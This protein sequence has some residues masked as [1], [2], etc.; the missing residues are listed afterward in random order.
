MTTPTDPLFGQQWHFALMGD[1]ETIWNEYTGAGVDVGVYDDGVEKTHVDLNDNYNSALEFTY[2][3]TYYDPFPNSGTDGHGTSVAGIIAAEANNGRGGVG[4]AWGAN[5]TGLNFLEDIQFASNAVYEAATL[6]AQNFDVMNN[7]WG[8]TPLFDSSQNLASPVAHSSYLSEMFGTISQNGRGGLGTI[9]TKAAG[10]EDLNSNGD[11]AIASRYTLTV[12]AAD[13]SGNAAD[14]SNYGAS[15]LVAAPAASV[16]TDRSGNDGYNQVGTSDGDPQSD[17]AFVTTF[18]GTS[19]ATPVTSGVV[20]LMLDANSGLGWRDVSE[21]LA[22]SASHTGSALGAAAS[23]FEDGAWQT[24]GG[25][26][27]NGGGA[28]FHTNYGYGMIDAYAATRMAEVWLD[29]TGGAATTANEQSVTA[30]YTGLAQSLTDFQTRTLNISV[31]QDIEIEYAYVTLD[32]RHSYAEDLRITLIDPD[33]NRIELMNGDGGSAAFD[34]RT[35]WTFG[36]NGLRGQTSAGT[37]QVEAYDGTSGDSGTL[38]DV[39]LEFFGRSADA[40]DIHHFTSDFQTYQAYEAGRGTISDTNGGTDWLNFSAIADNVTADLS[41]GSSINVGGANWGSLAGGADVFENI[42]TGDGNDTITGNS[43]ANTLMGMRGDDT[44]MGGL[45]ADTI[46]GGA[47]IDTV[48]YA[49]SSERVVIGLYRTGQVGTA[50]GDTLTSIERMIGSD[51]N[52]ML[53]GG[54]GVALLEMYGGAGHDVLY[55]YVGDSNLYGEAGNDILIGRQGND[56]MDGGSGIDTVFY[57]ASDGA[58]E[59]NLATGIGY[60]ADA[61]GDTYNLIESVVGSIYNDIIYGNDASNF[62]QGRAGADEISG[63]AGIDTFIGGSGADVFVFETGWDNDYISDF[64]DGV[65][66]LDVSVAGLT[67]EDF[68]MSDTAYGMRLNYYDGATYHTISIRDIEVS[69]IT[70]DDFF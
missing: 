63:G 46:D 39:D 36:V 69:E 64:E 50:S 21:I 45:G 16:T 48:S 66:L 59:V 6:H 33:G 30:T 1:I 8:T 7:S 40:D 42:V 3:G 4:V 25:S 38:Y 14:Y 9:I 55:D 11:G 20:A 70:S 35:D 51:H 61:A 23:G 65:D 60:L 18:G 43:L 34:T 58:V 56:H 24:L 19:A 49:D 47:G 10:N 15:I 17:V 31:A 27:W 53:I 28:S 67:F 44:F 37:W 29:M 68:S 12:S 41:A 13:S 26:T 57:D 52:D 62:L 32:I 54:G 2:L 5:I 22:M